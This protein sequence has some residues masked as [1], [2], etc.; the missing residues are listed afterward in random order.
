MD[1]IDFDSLTNHEKRALRMQEARRKGTHTKEEWFEMLEFFHNTCCRCLGERGYVRVGKDHIIP[2]Y[3]G[4]SDSI[5]N[6]QPLCPWCNA[7]KGPENFD[8]RPLLAD[9]LGKVLPSK[10]LPNG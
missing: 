1:M 6:L 5:K 8:W 2:V 3:Q 7:S 10:W 4:G 9:V